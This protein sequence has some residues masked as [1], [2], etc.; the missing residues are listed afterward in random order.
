MHQPRYMFA[1]DLHG[2][3]RYTQQLLAAYRRE[4]PDTL[5]LLGDILYHGPRNDLPDGYD[6]KRVIDLLNPLAP[7]ILCVRGN[8]DAEVDQQ[9][10]DFPLMADYALLTVDGHRLFLTHGHLYNTATPPKLAKGDVLIHGH[11]HVPAC[12]HQP[13]GWWYLNPGSVSIPKEGSARGYMIL[14]DGTFSWKTL[15]GRVWQTAPLREESR[16]VARS[17]F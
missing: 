9:V 8:C 4:Q 17:L 15:D 5:I 10:L 16:T 6:P 14:E 11:T 7:S 1:S 3:A 2:S 13:D 12:L